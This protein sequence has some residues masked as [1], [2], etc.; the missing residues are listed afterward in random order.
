MYL[1]TRLIGQF[2]WLHVILL[3]PVGARSQNIV[4]SNVT[5]AEHLEA[6]ILA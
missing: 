5:F 4:M 6:D 1:M 3:S 2:I